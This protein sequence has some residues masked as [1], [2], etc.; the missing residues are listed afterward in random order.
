MSRE[1]RKIVITRTRY[2][3]PSPPNDLMRIRVKSGCVHHE[4]YMQ[5]NGTISHAEVG[6]PMHKG[7]SAKFARRLAWELDR[8]AN[9]VEGMRAGVSE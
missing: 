8:L 1:K 9:E 2:L 4:F 7:F 3:T 6:S 5:E